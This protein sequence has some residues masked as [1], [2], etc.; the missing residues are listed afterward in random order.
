MEINFVYTKT[1][2]NFGRQNKF[3]DAECK[4]LVDIE[5]N[6]ELSSCF[7]DKKFIDRSAQHT[8]QQSEHEVITLIKD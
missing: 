6:D 5:P 7:V 4:I 8:T 1:R 2:A 3:S